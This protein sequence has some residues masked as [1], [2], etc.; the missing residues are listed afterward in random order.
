MAADVFSKTVAR[1]GRVRPALALA[2]AAWVC[3]TGGNAPQMDENELAGAREVLAR[4]RGKSGPYLTISDQELF[5]ALDL[6][7]PGLEEVRAAVAAGDCDA[8]YDAWGRYWSARLKPVYYLDDKTYADELT[9]GLPGIREIVLAKAGRIWSEDFRHSTYAPKR[10]GRTFRWADDSTSDTAY[11]GFHYWF[12]AGE[13]GRAYLLT[14]A[15]KYPAMFRELVCSWWDALPAMAV[16]A[17]CGRRDGVEVMW[18]SGLGSSI[19]ALVMADGYWLARRS[20]EFTRELHRK[21]LRIFLGH[22]RYMFDQHL[23]AYS[24]SNFQASQCCWAATVGILLPEFRESRQWLDAALRLTRTRIRKNYDAD[25]AQLEMCPQYHFT[26]MRD[27]TRVVWM[28]ERNGM[29]DLAGDEQLWRKLEQIYDFPLRLA[30]PTGHGAAINSGVYGNE[31]LVFMPVGAQLFGSRRHAWAAKRY[32]E[33]GF[34]PVAKSVSEYVQFI[35]GAWRRALNQARQTELPEPD[36]TNDLMRDSGIAVL[37]S[38]WGP[39]ALSMVFDFNRKPYGGHPYPG[40]LSFDLWG[41]GAA[42]VVNPGSTLSYSMPEY[43]QWCHRTIGHNTVM[44]NNQDQQRP[45]CAELAAWREG[46]RVTLAAATTDTYLES[47]GVRH[48][49]VI[50]SVHGEYF[51]VFDRLAGGKPGTPLAWLLHSPQP[52]AQRPDGAVCSPAGQPGLLVVPDSDTAAGAEAVLDK[53]YSAVPVTW[54]ENYKP[55][56]AW[57][58][59][60]AFLRL[61]RVVDPALGGQTYG[62]LLV[63]FAEAPPAVEVARE[64]SAS[65]DLCRIRVK[66]ADREDRLTIDCRGDAP[67]L[68]VTRH[69][70]DGRPLWREP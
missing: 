11:I 42:L 59:D 56:D 47:Q 3:A 44:V 25:G 63:P 50:V 60:V 45:H 7:R 6:E 23:R 55:L 1:P 39:D 32:I 52:L 31:W 20:P 21:I 10:V 58:D 57:R 2:F 24:H 66:W 27:I 28:L 13:L 18:N 33:A 34:V 51:F 26:G 40:R 30:H 29:N 22:A 15:E 19:R 5:A 68:E 67:V 36:F 43:G 41:C 46:R 8:A 14:G 12:W 9:R 35:D 38:G 4:Q 69:D 64:A 54:R 65:P 53:S 70:A 37:R 16:R 61:N 49:R 17:R 62:V 48:L